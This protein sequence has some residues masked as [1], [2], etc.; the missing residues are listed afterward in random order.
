[1]V[2]NV[3][4]PNRRARRASADARP[5]GGGQLRRGPPEASVLQSRAVDTRKRD[6]HERDF[7]RGSSGRGRLLDNQYVNRRKPGYESPQGWCE[8]PQGVVQ[9]A[10]GMGGQITRRCD[11]GAR[12]ARPHVIH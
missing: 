9:I 2:M 8:S 3:S 7:R 6:E 12:S 1:M 11:C 10:P 5:E 4:P